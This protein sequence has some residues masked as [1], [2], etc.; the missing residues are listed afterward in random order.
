MREPS[1]DE[2]R[3]SAEFLEN[4]RTLLSTQNDD[5]RHV[6]VAIDSVNMR[7]PAKPIVKPMHEYT[8]EYGEKVLCPRCGEVLYEHKSR[9][10]KTYS[11]YT[12]G[13]VC[14]RISFF[15][16]VTRCRCGQVLDWEE[17]NGGT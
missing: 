9:L 11:V 3:I 10:P 4:V 6:I 14:E 16:P 13:A 7:I 1:I 12:C 5:L 2:L 17:K 15:G 8:P